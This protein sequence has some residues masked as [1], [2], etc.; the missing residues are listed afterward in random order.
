MPRKGKIACVARWRP[1]L[2]EPP[3]ESPSTRK[4]SAL[5]GSRSWQSASLPGNAD[6][7]KAPLRR[8]RS[9]A[10]RAASRTCEA[11]I[12]L[13]TTSLAMAGCSS[14]HSDMACAIV[15]LTAAFTS[16]ETNLSLVWL[17]NLG[18]GTLQETT[19]TMPSRISSPERLPLSPLSSFSLWA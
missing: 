5:V 6:E 17:L 12:A 10:L 15:E 3:A 11:R 8:T 14:N 18:S 4:I 16:E 19:A 1:C 9:R 7:S 2:A 13:E